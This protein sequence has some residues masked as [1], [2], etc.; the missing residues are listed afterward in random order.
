MVLPTLESFRGGLLRSAPPGEHP[1]VPPPPLAQGPE[2]GSSHHLHLKTQ[3]YRAPRHTH[4]GLPQGMCTLWSQ[5]AV[6]APRLTK[7]HSTDP[8]MV[9]V[10]ATLADMTSSPFISGQEETS[11]KRQ[12]LEIPQDSSQSPPKLALDSGERTGTSRV[13]EV[14][15]IPF[16]SFISARMVLLGAVYFHTAVRTP[17]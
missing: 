1:C 7:K 13:R 8:L 3:P 6:S 2:V 15:W 4:I 17:A 10:F 9:G 12:F 5:L 16:W 11:E 14:C